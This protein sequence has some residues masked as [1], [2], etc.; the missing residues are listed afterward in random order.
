ME[1]PF[2]DQ[3]KRIKAVRKALKKTQKEFGEL[4]KVDQ[5]TISKYENGEL[6]LS[7]GAKYEMVT[8]LGVPREYIEE[9]TGRMFIGDFVDKKES[10][11][12]IDRIRNEKLFS[13]KPKGVIAVPIKAQA[14]Y[15]KHFDDTVYQS[16]LDRIYFPNSPYDGD[17]YRFFQ[18][19]GDSMEYIDETT[20]KVS[21][22]ED[23][24]WVLAEKVPKEDWK[25]NL[26][27]YYVYV[28]I[29]K[30]RITLKRILQDNPNEIVL[31]ADNELYGQER[32]PLNEVL[33]IWI[34]RRKLD[35]SAPPPRRIQIKV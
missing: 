16:E 18:V 13:D 34:F 26:R 23:Q 24:S 7:K 31:H 25:E 29:T 8:S 21:G 32:I 17:N 10:F 9:G 19:E 3:G 22:I 30:N 5:T 4:L 28:I 27:L 12:E 6:D 2:I 14:N 1:K 20:G 35:W 11:R 33:E 15:T